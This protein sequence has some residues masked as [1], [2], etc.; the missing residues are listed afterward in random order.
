MWDSRSVIPS[1]VLDA[2]ECFAGHT[3]TPLRKSFDECIG[4]LHSPT[5]GD[6][7]R[8]NIVNWAVINGLYCYQQLRDHGVAS[9]FNAEPTKPG[10]H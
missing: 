1:V 4:D 9:Q 5:L 3:I 7:S 10:N 6:L 8:Q 2:E